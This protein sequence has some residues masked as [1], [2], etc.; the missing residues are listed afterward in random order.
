MKYVELDYAVHS[1]FYFKRAFKAKNL[2]LK[3]N[4]TKFELSTIFRFRDMTVE[5][6]P[7]KSIFPLENL[8]GRLPITNKDFKTLL[9][10]PNSQ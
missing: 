7:L 8:P 9:H 5:I 6:S 2:D 3:T 1:L 4:F 10:V